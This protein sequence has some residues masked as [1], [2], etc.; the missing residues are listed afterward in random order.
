MPGL[1]RVS[2]KVNVSA[3]PEVAFESSPPD[4]LFPKMLEKLDWSWSA[5]IGRFRAQIVMLTLC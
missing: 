2:G 1:L 5:V 3:F 4:Q